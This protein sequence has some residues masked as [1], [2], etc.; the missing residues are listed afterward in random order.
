MTEEIV[1]KYTR[2]E[3]VEL[4]K[5]LDMIPLYF[6]TCFKGIFLN[7]V[8][9]LK[10]LIITSLHLDKE[11]IE[12]NGVRGILKPE[13]IEITVKNSELLKE[14]FDEKNKILDVYV[15]LNENIY[16]LLEVNTEKFSDVKRRNF[17]QMA[18]VYSTSLLKKGEE[19]S[20]LNDKYVFQLNINTKGKNENEPESIILIYDVVKQ[21]AYMENFK[22]MAKYLVIYKELYYNGNRE[23]DVI[24]MATLASESFTELYDILSNILDDKA[25]DSFIEDVIRMSKDETI[26]EEWE[27]KKLNEMV[28]VDK[29]ERLINEGIEKGIEKGSK[30][31]SFEIA[32]KMLSKGMK[33]NDIIELTNLSKEEIENLR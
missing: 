31:K 2:E 14:C 22:I 25:R 17:T 26:I 23:E 27:L 8:D 9:E 13:D 28:E 18:K 1:K 19:V 30:Q 29:K 10:R 4:D 32:K 20:A 16:V 12:V 15:S 6:D 24:W 21:E 11:P 5:R 33:I 3:L 7:H